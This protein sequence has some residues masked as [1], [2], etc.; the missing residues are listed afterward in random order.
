[1]KEYIVKSKAEYIIAVAKDILPVYRFKLIGA[2]EETVCI[3]K[4]GLCIKSI[5]S[6]ITGAIHM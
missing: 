2:L 1:M 3:Q 6:I 5:N 4:M